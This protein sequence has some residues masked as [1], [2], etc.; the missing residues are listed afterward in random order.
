V[1]ASPLVL[2]LLTALG[3]WRTI[4]SLAQTFPAYNRA[5]IARALER[6]HARTL[7]LQRPRSSRDGDGLDG[8]GEWSPAAAFFHFATRDV[9]FG[10]P[11]TAEAML[12][13]KAVVIPPPAPT[14]RYRSG[15]RKTLPVPGTRNPFAETLLKRRTWRRFGRASIPLSVLSRLLGLTWGVQGWVDTNHGRVAFKTSPS[16]GARHSIEAYVI[17]SRVAGLDR[18]AYHYDSARHELRLIRRLPAIRF[19]DYIPRQTWYDEAGALV[20]M[21][22]VFAR[23]QWRYPHPRSY[24][25]ILYEAGHHCQTFL[26]LAT[27]L[28]LAPFCTGALADS[29]LEQTLGLDGATE[30]VLYACGVGSRPHGA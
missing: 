29:A 16:G 22:S 10:D 21:T 27:S 19:S 17:A 2:E 5:A 30:S 15:A 23:M 25:S 26:L 24:R 20:V 28:E 3:G 11:A 18:G 6:L 13:R 8:W 12:R 9:A 4:D 1:N 14:K 7:V